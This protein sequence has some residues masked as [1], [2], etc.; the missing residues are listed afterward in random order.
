[1]QKPTFKFLHLK[2]VVNLRVVYTHGH[3]PE[4][5]LSVSA[6]RVEG[7]ASVVF[8]AV[9]V[10]RTDSAN[11]FAPA[12]FPERVLGDLSQLWKTRLALALFG[13]Q[14]VVVRVEVVLLRADRVDGTSWRLAVLS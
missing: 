4:T 14:A 12:A 9:Q 2:T 7:P 5:K 10:L 1:M 11:E 8:G 3:R 13:E 6:K